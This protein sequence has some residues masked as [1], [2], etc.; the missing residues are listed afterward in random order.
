MACAP[1]L[2][3][4]WCRLAAAALLRP[5]ARELPCAVGTALKKQK[6]K[7]NNRKQNCV[8]GLPK[9][10]MGLGIEIAPSYLFSLPIYSVTHLFS[11][12]LSSLDPLLP[13]FQKFM[14]NDKKERKGDRRERG[15]EE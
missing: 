3:C 2:L 5:L 8:I 15:K 1:L 7:R 6:K 9:I 13:F 12:H 10:A 4:L 14:V 11:P